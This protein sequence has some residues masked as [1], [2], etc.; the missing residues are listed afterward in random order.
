[1][2][3]YKQLRESIVDRGIKNLLSIKEMYLNHQK[4]KLFTNNNLIEYQKKILEL[5]ST[6]NILFYSAVQDFWSQLD[7]N[8]EEY[9]KEMKEIF[10]QS[11]I[12][13][14][15]DLEK[16]IKAKFT[17]PIQFF[18]NLNNS[19]FKSNSLFC[20]LSDK[21]LENFKL[22]IQKINILMKNFVEDCEKNLISFE[23]KGETS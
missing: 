14:G 2:L 1:M 11:I 10:N 15:E 3:F 4:I 9:S 8:T 12:E 7:R 5:H 20:K 22:L 16:N 23:Q 17:N 19:F 13:N 18:E 21:N 6:V